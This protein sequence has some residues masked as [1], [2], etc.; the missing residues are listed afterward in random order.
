MVRKF[1]KHSC[2]SR[3]EEA[4]NCALAHC[5]CNSAAEHFDSPFG[6]GPKY[7]SRQDL[8]QDSPALKALAF[9]AVC[10][11]AKLYVWSSLLARFVVR[12]S[13]ESPRPP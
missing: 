10:M 6:V 11:Y 3:A 7:Y 8:F 2:S 5:R 4:N 9:R 13:S 1:E 12:I